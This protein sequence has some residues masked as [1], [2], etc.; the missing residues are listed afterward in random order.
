MPEMASTSRA[1]AG[2]G[3]GMALVTRACSGVDLERCR[4]VPIQIPASRRADWHSWRRGQEGTRVDKHGNLVDK[5]R[6]VRVAAGVWKANRHHP[7]VIT[8]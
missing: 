2:A 6:D 3:G 1:K 4:L 8:Q 5:Q 7:I